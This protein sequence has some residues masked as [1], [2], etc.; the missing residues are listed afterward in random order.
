M[1]AVSYDSRALKL[2]G[3][4][5][6]VLS[7]AIHYPRSTPDMWPSL[8][9]ASREAGLNAIE[10]YVFW[11]LHERER[12]VY[13]FSHRLDLPRFLGL[14][15]EHGLNV[16]L[17]I[18]PYVCAETSYGGFPLWL[19]DIPGVEMRTYNRPF[20]EEVER[21]VGFLCGLLKPFFAPFGGPVILVQAENEY[22]NVAAAYG[23]D[24]QRYLQWCGRMMQEAT[25]GVPVIMCMGATQGT[26]ETING[27]YAHPKI[28]EYRRRH[29]DKPVLWTEFYSG[30]YD[31][32]GYPHHIRGA[33]DMAYALA[34]FVA[35]G[36]AGANYYMWHGGTNFGREGMY[37]Q[38]ASYDFDAP[39][40]EYGKPT[41]KYYHLLKLHRILNESAHI[42]LNVDVPEIRQ[43][44]DEVVEFEWSHNS[45]SLVFICNDSAADEAVVRR[46]CSSLRLPPHSV[47]I[48]RDG[49]LLMNTAH[50]S[51]ARRVSRAMRP[52][53]RTLTGLGGWVEPMPDLWPPA[54]RKPTIVTEP[55][56]QLLLTR[57]M[58]DYAW[59]CA[60]LHV[61][62][63]RA[64]V[65]MLRFEAAADVLYVY[66]DGKLVGFTLPPLHENRKLDGSD[67]ENENNAPDF[68]QEFN[69]KLAA[70]AHKLQIL[71]ASA[72]LIKGDWMLGGA[73]MA[74]ERKGIWGR[75]FWR[76]I[77]LQGPWRLSV[78]LLGERLGIFGAA[79]ELVQWRADLA[80]RPSMPLRWW[81]IFFKKP[82]T[83]EPL[84]LDMSTMGRGLL[85]L[86]GR[87][88][89]RYWLAQ[90]IGKGGTAPGDP[91]VSQRS[92]EPT[93][94]YYHLPAGWLEELNLLVVFEEFGGN[95]AGIRL[96]V[97]EETPR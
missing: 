62:S 71:C 87:L 32:W 74:R 36:G 31:T 30:W 47:V 48:L 35:A 91:V 33:E 52:L 42:F 90:A 67:R 57:D 14:A 78:G 46:G 69:I 26:L 12:K 25:F 54:L 81:R 65:G 94:R 21:W 45:Q 82:Y 63:R 80:R 15:A 60:D 61:E 3:R 51:A 9:R 5:V 44:D 38:T 59:Y 83:C 64:G 8:M 11:N 56:E 73:N 95:P 4:R 49:E 22:A 50:L 96:C 40:D 17:R 68:H 29:P 27:F 23:E 76:D 88:L 72:G 37:L 6:L 58:T 79:G 41:A 2:D 84:A 70:G 39:L 13:D 77:P 1:S 16:I 43:S 97:W 7:G 19:R 55:V 75:V 86:N 18:G 20:M 93:Q 53:N 66:I 85:W 89:C 24:G 28:E 92:S 34:R 10:T